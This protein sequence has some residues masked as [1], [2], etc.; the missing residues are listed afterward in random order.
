MSSI[1]VKISV[2]RCDYVGLDLPSAMLLENARCK[3]KVEFIVWS[4]EAAHV[5]T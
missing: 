1:V 2:N 3:T 4:P 5:L